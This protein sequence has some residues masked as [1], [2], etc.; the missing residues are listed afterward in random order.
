MKR[1]ACNSVL[2]AFLLFSTAAAQNVVLTNAFPNLTFRRPILLTHGGD[3]TDRVFVV[4]QDGFVHVL[5]NDSSVTSA[6]VFL[7][8]SRRLSSGGGEEGLLGLAFPP[9]FG[10][11]QTFYVNYTATSPHQTNG[12]KTVV[13]RYKVSAADPNMADTSS[14]EKLLEVEQPFRNHNGGMLA[15]GPD[16]NLYIA[17]GDGGSGNDPNN[18][19]QS[20]TT[21]L[22]KILRIDVRTTSG[23]SI[24]SDNPFVGGASGGKGEIWAYG[25]RNPWRFSF[26]PVTGQLWAA[27]VGQGAREEVDIIIRGG[28]YGWKI[29]EGSICRPGGG[30]CDPTGLILPVKD[31]ARGLGSSITGGYVYRGSRVQELQ[32]AYVYGD[33]GSGNIFLLRYEGGNVTADS[34]L[35]PGSFAISSFGV[36]EQSELYVVEYGEGGRIM[37]IVRNPGSTSVAAPDAPLRFALEQ[38]YPNP[39]NPKTGIRYSVPTQSGRDGQV[40]GGSNVKLTVYDQLGREVAVLVNEKKLP[41][42]YQV[43]FDGSGLASGMYIYRLSAG[44]RV[45]SRT[46]LLLR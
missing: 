16:S 21:L 32:G 28:N 39:F 1:Q 29:M 25:L 7:D 3:Q 22:G 15:F 4:R 42:S 11:S 45:E 37:K 43:D 26:D 41:G 27:D 17:L 35:L 24:P 30:L 38:N 13:A 34:V 46:M 8:I 20:L 6:P 9:D 12:I 31:Y 19:G 10:S 44:A 2:L 23:Y 5:P 33:F 14:E 18:N 36:D 40:P